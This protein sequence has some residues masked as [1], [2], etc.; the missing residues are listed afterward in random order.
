[1]KAG[2]GKE[3]RSPFPNHNDNTGERWLAI[4]SLPGT[5]R[6][7]VLFICLLG[8]HFIIPAAVEEVLIIVPTSQTR[9]AW[10][11]EVEVTGW[12]SYT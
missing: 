1:M 3:H 4:S 12:K 5:T 6:V 10:P 9:R 7:L 8:P 2:R 11:R